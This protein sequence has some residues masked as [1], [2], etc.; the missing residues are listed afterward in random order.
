MVGIIATAHKHDIASA[1][2]IIGLLE[3]LDHPPSEVPIRFL[4]QRVIQPII[5]LL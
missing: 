3:K 4:D 1:R 5:L 2:H